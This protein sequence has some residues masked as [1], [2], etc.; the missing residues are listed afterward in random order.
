MSV[1]TLSL[2]RRLFFRAAAFVFFWYWACVLC[3]LITGFTLSHMLSQSV[4]CPLTDLAVQV[5]EPCWICTLLDWGLVL[6][7]SF[8]YFLVQQKH[9]LGAYQQLWMSRLWRHGVFLLCP[10]PTTLSFV[11][12]NFS[13]LLSQY[14]MENSK[15]EDTE[16]FEVETR[17][18][19]HL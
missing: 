12:F 15:A 10:L 16:E 18:Q 8:L 19:N 11:N 17:I 6:P 13:T 14:G 3:S 2:S 5:S 9:I 4:I 7:L 1:D